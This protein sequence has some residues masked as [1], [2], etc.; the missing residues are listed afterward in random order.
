M[1][2]W[3]SNGSVRFILARRP[4]DHQRGDLEGHPTFDYALVWRTGDL[5]PLAS[6]FVS[7]VAATPNG[8]R[9]NATPS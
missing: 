4:A 5:N 6:A 8:R 2:G 3:A 7:L 1:D 9:S